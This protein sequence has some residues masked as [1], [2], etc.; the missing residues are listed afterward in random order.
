MLVNPV[1]SRRAPPPPP[2]PLTSSSLASSAKVDVKSESFLNFLR[3]KAPRGGVSVLC[4]E[5]MQQHRKEK[6][7]FLL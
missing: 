4:C 3:T 2:P 6:R 7:A 1:V 5:R